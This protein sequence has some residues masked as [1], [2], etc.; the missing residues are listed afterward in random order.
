MGKWMQ[1]WFRRR[2]ERGVILVL[3]AMILFGFFVVAALALDLSQ[4]SANVEQGTQTAK[5]AALSALQGYST[6][7][8]DLSRDDRLSAALQQANLVSGQNL[9]MTMGGKATGDTVSMTKDPVT[10]GDAPTLIAGK[11]YSEAPELYCVNPCTGSETPPCFVPLSE[12][13]TSCEPP[14]A[15]LDSVQPNS[16]R[17]VGKY[18]SNLQTIFSRILGSSVYSVSVDVISAFAPR[19]GMFLVDIS[20][21][22][23]RQT[24]WYAKTAPEYPSF[25][26]Y[27]GGLYGSSGSDPV[28]DTGPGGWTTLNPRR[29][30]YPAVPAGAPNV[31]DPKYTTLHYRSD[32]ATVYTGTQPAAPSP[33]NGL[34]PSRI[35]AL[36]DA[37]FNSNPDYAEYHPNPV[38]QGTPYPS[39]INYSADQ[40][41]GI[42]EVDTY[43]DAHYTGPEPFQSIFKGLDSAVDA[44]RE[45]AVTGD[46]LGIVFFDHVLSW[47][48]VINL[49]SDFD[50][51]KRFTDL[52]VTN[53]PDRGLQ[54]ILKHGIFP[55]RDSMSNV[56]A[57]A[58]EALRQFNETQNTGASSVDFMVY[59]GDGLMNCV[60]DASI[61]CYGDPQCVS[62]ACSETYGHYSAAVEEFR[63]FALY[64]LLPRKISF[65]AILVGSHVGPHTL[66]VSAKGRCITDTEARNLKLEF[67]R[68]QIADFETPAQ[69]EAAYDNMSEAAPFYE[70]TDDIYHLTRITGG[71]FG[72]VRPF[73]NNPALYNPTCTTVDPPRV[74][75]S[76]NQPGAEVTH[77]IK[78]QIMQA[79]PYMI[80]PGPMSND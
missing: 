59:F 47:P 16:F 33:Y 36:S 12:V 13:K 5:F 11:Y 62:A 64:T 44:F 77:Y 24:H 73:S 35:R 37:D 48:R 27:Y 68:G 63:D 60:S 31:N 55:H 40:Q 61:F 46:R 69:W 6:A 42:Y 57:A 56:M 41:P 21:S 3:T 15:T 79:N 49:S 9:L 74:M 65:S 32:Y 20:S 58:N 17:M 7:S 10:S 39:G 51:I 78:D 22:T 26:S 72:P 70:A 25:Y 54:L 38:P 1:G 29:S 30:D 45:R 8:S 50:Y 67:T 75:Y 53:D 66:A 43:R 2:E 52:S 4:M 19:R 28:Y 76:N 71:V 23:F 18:F 14:G 80:V 34:T